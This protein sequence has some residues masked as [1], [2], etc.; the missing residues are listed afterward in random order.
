MTS[1]IPAEQMLP[2]SGVEVLVREVHFRRRRGRIERYHN[3]TTG[4]MYGDGD[5]WNFDPQSEILEWIPLEWIE[6][7]I[8]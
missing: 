4:T 8:A 7:G 6:E 2:K 1:W 3:Y 5:H